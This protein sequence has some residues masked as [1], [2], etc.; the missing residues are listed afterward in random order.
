MSGT[1][2]QQLQVASGVSTATSSSSSPAASAALELEEEPSCMEEEPSC[3]H[4]QPPQDIGAEVLA[5]TTP[6]SQVP[7]Y[8]TSQPC[9]DCSRRKEKN[10]SLQKTCS[11][12][13]KRLLNKTA[14]VESLEIENIELREV[15]SKY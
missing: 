5:D 1:G 12:L 4:E 13:R 10:E 9:A 15:C 11:K 2:I 8:P 7:V 3:S 14:M 6:V